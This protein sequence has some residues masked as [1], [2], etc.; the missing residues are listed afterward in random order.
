MTVLTNT[1]LNDGYRYFDWNVDCGDAGG[2]KNSGDVYR[3]VVNYLN[4]NQTNV[5]LMHDFQNNYK[6]LNALRDIIDYGIE[7]GYTFASLD[8]NTPLVRH[9]VN[10]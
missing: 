4:H 3:N 6:T 8:M 2:A 9:R 1:V 7:N 5:V 10:N